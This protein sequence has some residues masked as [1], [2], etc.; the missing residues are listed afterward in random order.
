MFGCVGWI[1]FIQTINHDAEAETY[2]RRLLT[3]LIIGWIALSASVVSAQGWW[4]SVE[5]EAGDSSQYLRYG[6]WLLRADSVETR[7]SGQSAQMIA[8]G[9][10]LLLKSPDLSLRGDRAILSGSTVEFEVSDKL[11]RP[12]ASAV[13]RALSLSAQRITVELKQEKIILVQPGPRSR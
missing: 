4:V 12:R 7:G 10:V 13:K 2:M 5:S 1:I 3:F 9:N 6:E 8:E 11:V